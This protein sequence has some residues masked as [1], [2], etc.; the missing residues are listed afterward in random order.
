VKNVFLSFIIILTICYA[1]FASSPKNDLQ[2]LE[3]K[4]SVKSI[5]QT[6]YQAVNKSDSIIKGKRKLESA[7]VPDHY[8]V[9]NDQGNKIKVEEY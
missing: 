8:I 3:L 5:R 9:F 6:S 2:R 7:D 4:G 1:C